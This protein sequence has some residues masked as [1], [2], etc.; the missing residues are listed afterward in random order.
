[1]EKYANNETIIN[2]EI[3]ESFKEFI[4]CPNCQDI[5][6]E[7]FVCYS[8]DKNYCKKCKVNNGGKCPKCKKPKLKKKNNNPIIKFK[9]KCIKGCGEE[10]LFNDI[11]RHYKSNCNKKE[12]K[13]Q[14]LSKNQM[15]KVNR[16]DISHMESKFI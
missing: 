8:C 7:P 12:K 5:I 15:E 10:L 3:F 6:L 14:I 2:N 9:F 4:I 11:I 13:F 16:E 1:M